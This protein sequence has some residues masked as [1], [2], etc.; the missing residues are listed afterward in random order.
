MS[1]V[2]MP[3]V[4]GNICE[5]PGHLTLTTSSSCKHGEI[6]RS[7]NAAALA[8]QE[9]NERVDKNDLFHFCFLFRSDAIRRLGDDASDGIYHW[10]GH[11][12]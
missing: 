4:F 8:M 1:H 7:A 12:S 2:D 3:T 5:V 10:W 11:P 9:S 6:P